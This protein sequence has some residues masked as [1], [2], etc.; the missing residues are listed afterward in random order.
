MSNAKL[1][2][3]ISV[4]PVKP[5]PTLVPRAKRAKA[6]TLPLAVRYELMALVK[7]ADRS[8]PDA[9]LASQASQIAGRQVQQ[10]TISGYRK[11]FGIPSVRKPGVKSLQARIA[12]LETLITEQGF[13]VPA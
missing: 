1:K 2:T 5:A 4:K 12:M 13:E 7:N 6:P 9:T 3:A 8:T 10:Q 11:Q